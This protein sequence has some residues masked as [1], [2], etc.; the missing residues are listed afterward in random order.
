MRLV[1]ANRSGPDP[2]C[3]AMRTATRIVALLGFTPLLMLLTPQIRGQ[4]LIFDTPDSA[5]SLLTTRDAFVERLSPFDR[6][7]RMKT[8]GVVTEA[9]FL[10][11]VGASVLDWRP[12]ERERLEAAFELIRPG[13]NRLGPP[14]PRTL[15]LI[16]TSGREEGNAPYTRGDAIVLPD[17]TVSRPGANLGGILAHELFHVVSRANPALR[18]RLYSVIGF[19]P[20]G[21]V[22][23]PLNLRGRRITNPDAPINAHAIAVEVGGDKVLAVPILY[24]SAASYD[25]AKGGEFFSYLQV[26]L[27]LIRRTADGGHRVLED[28][29]GPR[30]FPIERVT[31]YHEQIGRNTGYIIHP[32]EVLADN[33]ALL[34]NAGSRAKSPELLEKLRRVFAAEKRVP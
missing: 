34:I 16:K 15:R 21:E 30:L 28:A 17:K 25:A 7:A 5:R 26:E 14:L 31:G 29:N 23:H 10:D 3:Y 6:A 12:A 20:C 2:P 11:F 18:D 9:Q 32:E 22:L 27:L 13:L 8:N 33:F 4:Q 24:S 1:L 19:E